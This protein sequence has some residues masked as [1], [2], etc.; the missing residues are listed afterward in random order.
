MERYLCYSHAAP[1]VQAGLS[2]DYDSGTSHLWWR[3]EEAGVVE[4]KPLEEYGIMV[5]WNGSLGVS[6]FSGNHV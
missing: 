4:K 6:V 3:R 2:S 5:R 1:R